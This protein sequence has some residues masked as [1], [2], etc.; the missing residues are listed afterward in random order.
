M[1]ALDDR[2]IG[3]YSFD[4]IRIKSLRDWLKIALSGG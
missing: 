4:I 1:E 2:Y 3:E